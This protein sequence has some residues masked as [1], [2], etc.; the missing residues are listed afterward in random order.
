MRAC[1]VGALFFALR[2][3]ASEWSALQDNLHTHL[4]VH[5]LLRIRARILFIYVQPQGWRQ[6]TSAHSAEMSYFCSAK[7]EL[8]P[9]PRS[10][11]HPL[12]FLQQP[13]P[14]LSV[15]RQMP[16]CLAAQ[17]VRHRTPKSTTTLDYILLRSRQ[18]VQHRG[19]SRTAHS[20][21]PYS[22]DAVAVG[23]RLQGAHDPALAAVHTSPSGPQKIKINIV[24]LHEQSA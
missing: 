15:L 1:V 8:Q 7:Q 17:A 24:L 12:P 2:S 20:L 23:H 10:R 13:N 14:H 19:T 22:T 6:K 16:L 5:N 9:H 11:W 4:L 18:A 21:M 3:I